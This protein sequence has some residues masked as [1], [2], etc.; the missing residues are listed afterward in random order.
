MSRRTE[1]VGPTVGLP[2]HRHFVRFFNMPV[3]Y[4]HGT[5]LF[6]RL[7]WETTQ[8]CPFT[9]CWGYGGHIL[10]LTLRVPTRDPWPWWL[11]NYKIKYTSMSNSPDQS[12]SLWVVCVLSGVV[13]L[14]WPLVSQ[15]RSLTPCS[16]PSSNTGPKPRPGGLCSTVWP[17]T[18]LCVWTAE[19]LPEKL[20]ISVSLNLIL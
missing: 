20:L 3:L 17:G 11:R 12:G 8:F 6:I 10:N 7:F 19:K 14:C 9:T 4:W 16:V 2:R 5:T 18:C 1:E 13:C 15:W